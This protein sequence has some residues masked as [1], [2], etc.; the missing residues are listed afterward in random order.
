MSFYWCNKRGDRAKDAQAASDDERRHSGFRI[1]ATKLKP[2]AVWNKLSVPDKNVVICFCRKITDELGMGDDYTGKNGDNY[3]WC[4][5]F[6]EAL[7]RKRRADT[8]YSIIDTSVCANNSRRAYDNLK[9]LQQL[10]CDDAQSDM[11]VLCILRVVHAADAD[12]GCVDVAWIN[13]HAREG[14]ESARRRLQS[15]L[16]F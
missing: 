1:N 16:D 4:Q 13:F 11:S 6:R 9:Q 5:L 15:F 3:R 8:T 2:L 14:D 12:R 7:Q 10:K